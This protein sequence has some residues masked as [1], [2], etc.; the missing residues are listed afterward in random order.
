MNEWIQIYH[1]ISK[2]KFYIN[3]ASFYISIVLAKFRILSDFA[4]LL[5]KN[6]SNNFK[7]TKTLHFKYF[8]KFFWFYNEVL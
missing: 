7:E 5:N 4:L 2:P 3:F 1:E 8:S 6:Q